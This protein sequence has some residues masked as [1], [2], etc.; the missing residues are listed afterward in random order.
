MEKKEKSVV[1]ECIEGLIDK[2]KEKLSKAR[3]FDLPDKDEVKALLDELKKL[4]YP[5]CFSYEADNDV[6]VRQA[7]SIK[8]R[9]KRL[10]ASAFSYLCEAK[11]EKND[12]KK[13]IEKAERIS[14]EFF[15]ALPFVFEI[16]KKY[17][18]A[19]LAG[20]PAA[21][22]PDL[23]ILTY[24]GIEATFTYRLA[25]VLYEQSVP[26]IPRMMTEI[27]HSKTGIDINPGAKIGE[28]FVID[29]GTGIV[30]GETTKIGE[31]VNIYQGVT[32]GAIS[33]KNARSLVGKKRH[34]TI[35]DDVTVYA[36]ATVLGGETVIGKGSVIGSSVFLTESV[37]PYT[38]VLLEK[39]ALKLIK[40]K[41]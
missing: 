36:G 8:E 27:A 37:P 31:R 26:L 41:K 38:S 11:G 24:P 9:L 34:P 20:D 17:V 35:E 22:D 23:I 13:A 29:H 12:C 30:I 21:T 10:I 15:S 7:E 2:S 18:M 6:C 5:F 14:D 4:I 40:R 19:T 33:L 39:P 3:I 25:H 32:L 1:N 28:S 16:F